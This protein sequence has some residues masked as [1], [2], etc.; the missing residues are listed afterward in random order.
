MLADKSKGYATQLTSFAKM[1]QYTTR[2]LDA[3]IFQ[4]EYLGKTYKNSLKKKSNVKMLS[5]DFI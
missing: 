3:G 4:D 2:E 5:I 1:I